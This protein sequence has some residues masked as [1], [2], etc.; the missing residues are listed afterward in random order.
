MI[1]NEVLTGPQGI[2]RCWG[3]LSCYRTFAGRRRASTPN[4]LQRAHVT[5]WTPRNDTPAS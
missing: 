1:Q 2:S 5:F 3:G 4:L